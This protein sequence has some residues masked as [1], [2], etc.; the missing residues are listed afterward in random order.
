MHIRTISLGIDQPRRIAY[1]KQLQAYGIICVREV[2]DRATGHEVRTSSFKI[3]DESTF[4]GTSNLSLREAHELIVA[5][6]LLNYEFD[7]DEQG[8]AVA[9]VQLGSENRAHFVVGSSTILPTEKQPRRGKL[10]TWHF[11]GSEYQSSP[12]CD[13]KGAPY[14]FAQLP[15]GRVAVTINAQVSCMLITVTP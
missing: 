11:D 4:E 12:I 7:E 10:I 13:A 5:A 2:L 8:T 6:V 15:N 3:V 1:S 14:A 9:A